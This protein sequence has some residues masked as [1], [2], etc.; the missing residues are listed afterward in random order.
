MCSMYRNKINTFHVGN[1]HLKHSD[2]PNT[3]SRKALGGLE[4]PLFGSQ[5]ESR[6]SHGVEKGGGGKILRR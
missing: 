2:P 1:I 6:A 5:P 4:V 3:M